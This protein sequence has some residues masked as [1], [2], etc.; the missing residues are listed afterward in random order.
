MCLIS[1]RR[2]MVWTQGHRNSQHAL[3]TVATGEASEEG[4]DQQASNDVQACQET[5]R[6]FLCRRACFGYCRRASIVLKTALEHPSKIR[7]FGARAP[8]HSRAMPCPGNAILAWRILRMCQSLS[9]M[10]CRG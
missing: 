10:G 3:H 8:E 6:R 7:I 2:S 1:G 9:N 4:P 5:R